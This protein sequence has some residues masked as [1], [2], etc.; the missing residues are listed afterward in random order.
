MDFK[1]HIENAWHLC[2]KNIAPLILITLVLSILS[3]LTLG[4]FTAVLLSGYVYSLLLL[5]RDGREPKIQDLF[6][7]LNLFLPLFL[8]SILLFLATMIGFKL[9]FLP[10]IAVLCMVTFGG[11]YI[12][13]LMVDKKLGLVDAVKGSWEMAVKG[14]IADHI[15]VVI[16]FIGLISIGSSVFIGT[17]FTQPFATILVL[18]VYIERVDGYGTIKPAAPQ[19]PFNEDS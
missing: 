7:H 8:L 6:S 3:I 12:L 11:I 2:L 16:L 13:P 4:L 10:G 5:I 19:A 18:S 1:S 15:V 14:N 17:L 9:F